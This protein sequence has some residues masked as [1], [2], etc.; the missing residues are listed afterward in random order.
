MSAP[1]E[2]FE[3]L[4]QGTPE[5]LQVRA[6]IAT[7]SNFEKLLV[8]PKE[9]GA[10]WS[11]TTITYANEVAGEIITGE[12]EFTPDTF[13]MRR[14]KEWEPGIRADYEYM[15]GTT[16][17]QVGFIRRG[18]AG[19]SPDGLVGNDGSIEIK[20]HK[21]KILVPMI[22][23]LMRGDERAIA[24]HRPQVQGNLWASGREWIDLVG[25]WPKLPPLVH[26][27]Y[28]DEP[29]IAELEVAIANFSELVDE[30]VDDVLR[31]GE[32]GVLP[33]AAE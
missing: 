27:V 19:A 18:R 10:R 4:E 21:P 11:E 13:D 30:I 5:W 7:A 33:I 16:V 14:G 32:H 29:F 9:K 24:K 31:Y 17:R 25:Y 6:G 2:I 12:P 15:T 20:T 26:R 22:R 1:V 23:G 3:S 28:R 8:K